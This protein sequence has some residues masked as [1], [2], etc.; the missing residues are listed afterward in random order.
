MTAIPHELTA[1]RSVALGTAKA[2]SSYLVAAVCLVIIAMMMFPLVVSFFASIK[3]P[4]EA[5]AVPP[6]YLPHALSLA[7]YIKVYNYQAGLPTYVF[8]SLSVAFLTILFCLALSVPAGYGLARF[9]IPG[10]EAIFLFLLASLMI[11][12]QALLT[13]LYLMFAPL[14]LTNS[15]VGLA[16]VH[17]VLQLPFSIYLMRHNFESVPRELEEAAIMD[18]CTSWQALLKV[19][20]PAVRPGM[21]TVVLFAFIQSWNEFI[22]ALIFMGRETSFTVPIML[23]AVR[24]GRF[25]TVDWGAL[26]AGIIIAIVP[27]VAIYVLLQRYYVSGFL[28]GAVK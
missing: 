4:Q 5:V 27:C 25:G 15:H 6:N 7:N 14:G 17:T 28:S 19:F 1:N 23:V 3:T 11:P 9:R 10:K 24:L 21:V 22:A 8:N 16:I 26:Q 20:L 12:Y 2:R 13:P 18:G